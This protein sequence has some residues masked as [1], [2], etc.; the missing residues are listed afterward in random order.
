MIFTIEPVIIGVFA[1]KKTI[2]LLSLFLSAM[3]CSTNV[4]AEEIKCKNIDNKEYV[5]KSKTITIVNNTNKTIYPILITSQNAV[6]QWL[7]G[8]FRTQDKY[9]QH[10][11]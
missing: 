3:T 2:G 10:F 6:N 7:Q 9:S 1:L 8:C 4:L 5:I 11:S